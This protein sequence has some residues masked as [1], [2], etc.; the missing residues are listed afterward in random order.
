MILTL[1]PELE[2]HVNNLVHQG[3]YPDAQAVLSDALKALVRE[4][5][6]QRIGS[7][8]EENGIEG[9]RIEQLLQTAEDSGD[10][11]AMTAQDWEDIERE[12]LAIV[13]S[14]KPR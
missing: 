13:N 5:E 2:Q 3:A 10:Y 1:P 14:R 4:Q 11:E 12:G 8:L 9:E 7:L 6:R